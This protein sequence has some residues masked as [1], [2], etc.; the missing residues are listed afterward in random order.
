MPHR[1]EP[2]AYHAYI[3]LLCSEHTAHATHLQS[4]DDAAWLMATILYDWH[5]Q[6]HLPCKVYRW[7]APYIVVSDPLPEDMASL[8]DVPF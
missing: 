8:D 4:W 6:H 5:Q 2:K 3:R 1:N 7:R